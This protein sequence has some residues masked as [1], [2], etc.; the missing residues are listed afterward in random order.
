MSHT[1]I[2]R[3]PVFEGAQGKFYIVNNKKYSVYF[4][5]AW[6]HEHITFEIDEVEYE[7]GPEACG[8][9]DAY[10]SIR[11]VFVGYCSNCL[12]QYHGSQYW[13]GCPVALGLSVEMLEDSD[14]W[15][16]YPYMSGIP[17]SAI[18][19]EEGADLTGQGVNLEELGAAI[20]AAEAREEDN[21][22]QNDEL[23]QDPE[24]ETYIP[25]YV[26]EMIARDEEYYATLEHNYVSSDE[27]DNEEI[28]NNPSENVTIVE[29]ADCD[30]SITPEPFY[31]NPHGDTDD[32]E[33]VN[34]PVKEDEESYDEQS[35]EGSDGHSVYKNYFCEKCYRRHPKLR[36]YHCGDWQ[37]GFMDC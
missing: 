14:M 7:T 32:E 34:E 2:T 5:I 17:K 16:Q 22:T 36:D 11:G 1:L 24:E 25:I 23:P 13:R 19:D 28:V 35:Y 30:R 12:R 29:G 21:D 4:P 3:I 37:E 26:S 31:H 9:C 27:E 8:N 15:A 6:A 10:G 33:E 20:A 18:G